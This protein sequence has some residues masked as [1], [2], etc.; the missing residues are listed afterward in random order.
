M[1]GKLGGQANV[2]GASGTWRD[3]T[4]NVN[5]L[6]ANLSTQV[7]AIAEVA[8]AVTKGDLSSS[9]K[10]EA[11][12]EM[13]DLKSSINKMIRNLK[14][15]TNTNT[16][17][18]WLK[19]NLAKFTRILQGQRDIFAV[20][21][22]LLS[23]LA[24]LVRSQHGLVYILEN[25]EGATRLRMMASYGFK[26]RKN[27]S[28]TYRIGEGLVGQCAYEKQRILL[29]NVP[30]D[31]VQITTGL[32]E[33]S[34]LNIILLP[35]L[36]EGQLK[37][38]IELASFEYFSPI[39][40]TFLEQLTE[41]V[42]IVL[43]TIET[44]S[45]TEE[46][47][48]Q[49]Q[50]LAQELQSQQQELQGSNEELE[51][52]ARQL[53]D[54]NT[55][56]ERKNSEIEVARKA[57]EEKAEQLA[58]TS[59]YKSEFLSNMSHELRTPLNSLLILSQQLSENPQGNL[60]EKQVNFAKTIMGS[61]NDLLSLINDILDL[62]KIESG[63]VT[64]DLE[65]VP[66]TDFHDDAER[67]FKQLAKTKGLQ[68]N[69]AIDKNLP[70]S[71]YTDGKRIR[72]VLKNL[73]SNAFKFTAK[74]EVKLSIT[75]VTSGW[76]TEN[77]SLNRADKVISFNV[78]DTGIGISKDK[79][80][81]IFEAFQ[82]ADG[83]TSRKY[84]GTGLGLAIS[85]EIATLLGGEISLISDPRSG[86]SFTLY[87]PISLSG[88]NSFR[89]KDEYP[90]E[91][92]VRQLTA[93]TG[94]DSFLSNET[95]NS[96]VSVKTPKI[97]TI[98]DDRDKIKD[99]DHVLL[100]VE[101]DPKFAAILL[102]AAHNKGYAGIITAYGEDALNLVR[103]FKPNAISLDI[104]LPDI[105]GWTVLDRLKMNPD[106]RHIPVHI[107]SVEEQAEIGLLRGAFAHLSK[108]ST[109]EGLEKAFEK[110]MNFV[111]RKIKKLL[112][113]EDNSQEATMIKDLIGNGDVKSTVVSD[114]EKAIRLLKKEPYDCMTLDLNLPGMSGFEV[115]EKIQTLPEAK[116]MPII[117]FTAKDL[118]QKEEKRLK[119]LSRD[120]VLKDVRSPER[121]L[122]EV[123]LFLHRVTANLPEPKRKIIEK[124]YNAEA[125]LT[126]KKILVVD[127]DVRNIFA[128]TSILERFNM[129]IFSAENGMNA[130]ELL[131]KNPDIDLILMDIMM[132]EMDGYETTANI[133]KK[134]KF[135]TLPIIA[136]TAKAMKGD[137]EK[138]IEAGAS[139]YISKPVLAEQLLSLM[140]V[141]LFK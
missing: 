21:Q 71:I 2:P 104:V 74:G 40:Q 43:N 35:I 9:I 57:I 20:S 121:L 37:A 78:T 117:V 53:S 108:P 51:E 140:R 112:I 106:T 59:K 15:T 129:E 96:K 133:R 45:R 126:G 67:N 25:F 69:I 84:G 3:L 99:G 24:P 89:E 98:K 115:I 128:I 77:R 100:I 38:V 70:K 109:P 68:F 94:M 36:F 116:D 105:D 33:A 31:Y 49:S 8:T 63:T 88:H 56:V 50:S 4:D 110:I 76:N 62:S 81:V 97:I 127:D 30:G 93:E 82:Q 114:G 111:D 66:I 28:T 101:D 91:I 137:R 138:C 130:I 113:V 86:S 85:R 125:P 80:N 19:T 54:Q 120:V 1:E 107:I 123:N 65:E 10:V 95:I 141:W 61:G 55:E 16:E 119:E 58:I 17:Q 6:A 72:Q 39:H 83:S 7:R 12:G 118:T 134:R 92:V 29:T 46:L 64:L 124:L 44:S 32:G 47:L 75:G 27:L 122:D 13:E 5:Q 26:E 131:E 60:N 79:Q 136:L 135:K 90:E 11:M 132:P 42:G 41:S 23:E 18:D 34:P 14:E 48:K 87:L 73:L 103:E 102:D 22:T 52:K 139:D